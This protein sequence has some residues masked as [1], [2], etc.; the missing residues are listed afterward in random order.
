MDNA[1]LSYIFF[2]RVLDMRM[3]MTRGMSTASRERRLL[4]IAIQDHVS[5]MWN[6]LLEN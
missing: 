2:F 1:Q 5:Y 4:T 6:F 3:R